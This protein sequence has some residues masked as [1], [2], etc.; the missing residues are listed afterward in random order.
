MVIEWH[1]DSHKMAASWQAHPSQGVSA[2]C[3]TS[4]FF[5]TA[6]PHPDGYAK[7]WPVG[8][9]S[10]RAL[11]H[12]VPQAQP[13]C[14]TPGFDPIQSLVATRSILITASCQV[15]IWDLN[16]GSC[17]KMFDIHSM[18]IT[19]LQLQHEQ[20]LFTGSAD[21][22]ICRIDLESG[23]WTSLVNPQHSGAGGPISGMTVVGEYLLS[24]SLS[25]QPIVAQWKLSSDPSA[26]TDPKLVGWLDGQADVQLIGLTVSNNSVLAITGQNK[27]LKW[28]LA[29]G[30]LLDLEAVVLARERDTT[31]TG[32]P[33][34]CP[35]EILLAD[36]TGKRPKTGPHSHDSRLAEHHQIGRALAGMATKSRQENPSQVPFSPQI[37][38]MGRPLEP[39][40]PL[41]PDTVHAPQRGQPQA[42]VATQACETTEQADH[43][44]KQTAAREVR[45]QHK[46]SQRAEEPAAAVIKACLLYTSPSPRDS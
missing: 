42:A 35:T 44:L 29:E 45:A 28:E 11:K 13:D 39:C 34:S 9:V 40:L 20:F 41:S 3:C 19:H 37:D 5:F 2:L 30:E 32:S 10:T 7:Q 4:K 36:K 33:R 15:R 26:Q 24:S 1:A 27:V 23:G 6:S 22:S 17:V 8:T 21:G 25:D 43:E 14:K 46:S 18:S 31:P 12:F 16:S 38:W